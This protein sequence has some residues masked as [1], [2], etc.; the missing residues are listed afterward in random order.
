M[1]PPGVI[2]VAES[3]IS[4]PEQIEVLLDAGVDAVLI[5]ESLLRAADPGE[6]LRSLVAAGLVHA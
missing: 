1:V 5:G 4:R 3:G 2:F 6:K